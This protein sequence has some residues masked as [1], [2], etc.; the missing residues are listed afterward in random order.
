MKSKTQLLANR[1]PIVRFR[2]GLFLG[3]G[4]VVLVTAAAM[5]WRAWRP[6]PD[7]DIP[8]FTALRGRLDITVSEVGN[9]R[10]S[11]Q[12][13]LKSEL[14]GRSTILFLVPE[15]T[16]VE[17]G[18]LLVEL[19][20][21]ALEDRRI[22]Q[23]I[24]VE[25]ADAAFI[26]SRENLEV[27]RNQTQ[28][29]VE[30]A[31]LDLQFAR[32]DLEHY[33]AGQH[34]N[35]IKELEARITLAREELQRASE[36]LKWS[37]ILFEEKYLSESEIQADELAVRKVELDVELAEN[38]L[39]LQQQFEYRRQITKLQ[40][41]VR[42]AEMALDRA[43]RKARS[44]VIQAEADL[45]AKSAELSQHQSRLAKLHEQIEK[46]KIK[47][48]RDGLVVYATSTRVQWRGNVEPLSEGQEVRERQEL[49]Y[50]PTASS[51]IA[52]IKIHESNL[53][54]VRPGMPVSLRVD[55]LPDSRFSGYVT[56]IAPLPDAMSAFMNPDLKL[57][58]T[59]I[60][61]EGGGDVLR[62]GMSCEVTIQIATFDDV[63]YVPVHTVVR[64]GTQTFVFVYTPAGIQR[65]PV[66]IGMHNHRMVH[67][68]EGLEEGERVLLAPPL[69]DRDVEDVLHEE[70]DPEGELD[71]LPMHERTSQERQ[72]PSDP[73]SE[74]TGRRSGDSRRNAG[75]RM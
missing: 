51:F 69:E 17:A 13:I 68:V 19:D 18:D 21:T 41:D 7:A 46:A 11:E 35:R 50:L 61:I 1:N 14:E 28:S 3:L 20:V 34:P 52:N 48:P 5:A 64:S 47:A 2:K 49:I 33:K 65:R 45:R 8:L 67:I 29:D 39:T 15:G 26:R 54:R 12:I 38:N 44:D 59:E 23:E 73:E 57:Y 60:R 62:T 25:N 16:Q 43:V 66:S 71:A 42:Q 10:P 22:E 32:E 72:R 36:K 31:E 4:F 55:A 53:Q 6:S 70:T 40:S 27:V 37:R 75:G 56:S 30:R 74:A 63:V 24:R 9:I 58:D